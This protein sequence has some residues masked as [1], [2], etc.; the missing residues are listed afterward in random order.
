M[1]IY[2][3]FRS[4]IGLPYDSYA[5]NIKQTGTNDP[6]TFEF[7]SKP[8]IKRFQIK[9]LFRRTGPGVYTSTTAFD[10]TMWFSV[11][12]INNNDVPYVLAT[13]R[14]PSGKIIFTTN[15]VDGVLNVNVE[16]RIYNP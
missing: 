4:P 2:P 3:R 1:S 8:R 7:V 11:T 14:D 5:L 13:K 9:I 15:G 12:K 16:I 10:S 6:T